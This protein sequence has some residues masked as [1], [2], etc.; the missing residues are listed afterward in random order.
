MR[1]VW[2]RCEGVVAFLSVLGLSIRVALKFL[3]SLIYQGL[4]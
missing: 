3:E 4:G 1:S 2:T